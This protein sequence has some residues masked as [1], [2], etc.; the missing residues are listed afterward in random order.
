[1]QKVFPDA[2]AS[3]AGDQQDDIMGL[4]SD[5][6]EDNDYNPDGPD[7]DAKVEVSGS[8][9]EGSDSAGSDSSDFSSVSEDLGAIG[10]DDQYL[11]L[12]SD[13]SEDD[14][15]DPDTANVNDD[16]EGESSSSDFTS[17]SE[18]LGAAVHDDGGSCDDE[19]MVPLSGADQDTADCPPVSGRRHV[20]RLDYK[21]L[22]DVSVSICDALLCSDVAPMPS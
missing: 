10:A 15:Y 11:G 12:P 1:L 4:P 19:T 18:D 6:S 22:Y 17:A 14:D 8:S 5:D 3:L 2:V 13:D 9:S 16:V 7:D 20:E 21:K